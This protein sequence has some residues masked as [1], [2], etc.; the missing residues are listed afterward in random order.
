MNQATA[1]FE[2]RKWFVMNT[3]HKH[4]A[5]KYTNEMAHLHNELNYQHCRLLIRRGS[6]VF[7]TIFGYFWFIS[8]PDALDWKDNFDL[9]MKE[10]SYGAIAGS[11]GEGGTS[12][13]D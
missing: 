4:Y 10:R 1:M 12:M 13:D 5:Q 3:P 6:V 11:S 9:K 7:A 2:L 8:E